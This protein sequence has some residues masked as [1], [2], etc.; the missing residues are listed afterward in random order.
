MATYSDMI[1]AQLQAAQHSPQK[2]FSTAVSRDTD[3]E[4]T[5]SNLF[6]AAADADTRKITFSNPEVCKQFL[7]IIDG[8]V[9]VLTR[10]S[11]ATTQDGTAVVLGSLSDNIEAIYPA[12]LPKQH[13]WGHFTSL[14]SSGDATALGLPVAP[15]GPETLEGPPWWGRRT[16]PPG[17][18]PHPLRSRY[19]N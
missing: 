7:L 13:V 3:K 4:T 2:L 9:Q 12:R 17:I 10:P 6:G 16:G 5:I 1:T 18:C 14:V 15:E 11:P 19:A 8:K